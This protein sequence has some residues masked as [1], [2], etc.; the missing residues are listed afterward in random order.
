MQLRVSISVLVFVCALSACARDAVAPTR[1]VLAATTS[2]DDTGLLEVI[3]A[4]F[5]RQHP[6]IEISGV[7]VGTG[8]ALELGR[9]GDAD[10][11][12]S[13]DSAAET[14]LVVAGSARERRSVMYNFFVIVGPN[15]DPARVRG[16]NAAAA[17]RA[18]AESNASFV[19][20]GDD[21]GTHRRELSVWHELSI[22][23][24]GQSW[25]VEAG[26]GMGDALLL[27]GQRRA[28]I[29]SDRATFLRFQPRVGL[30][31]LSDQ[32]ARLLNPY[33]VTVLEGK[34]AYAA[35]VFADWITS[36]EAQR[37]IGDF[38]K[39]EFGQ[40]LFTPSARGAVP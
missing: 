27:A 19:S 36:E 32:D 31:I 34:R 28:Y 37:L 10:L 4:E 13:H 39:A 40:A 24:R 38:G 26:L 18:I 22:D 30:Q 2:I 14:Q 25:Y 1:L 15:D 29:L 8:Q 6:E 9:R 7:A 20:R 16:A 23:P 17:F 5:A 35:T 3:V 12:L 33:G 21:S 11:L